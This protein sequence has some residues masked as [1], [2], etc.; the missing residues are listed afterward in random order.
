MVSFHLFLPFYFSRYDVN[1]MS[2]NISVTADIDYRG[3]RSIVSSQYSYLLIYFQY[4][5]F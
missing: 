1:E 3:V 5:N 4:S 2:C